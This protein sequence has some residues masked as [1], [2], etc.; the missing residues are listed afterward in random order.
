MVQNEKGEEI[1]TRLTSGWRVCI[2]YRRLNTVTRKDHFPLPFIDQVLEKVSGH[3]FYCF[4]DGYSRYF[5][6]EIEID[7][8]YQENTTFTCPFGTYAY[9]IMPFWFM[10][11][12]YNIPTM[13]VKHFQ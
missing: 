4:L 8:E 2:D 9:R 11:C 5:Q 6:I 13:Y 7:V 10:Q 3:P 1:T 12:T